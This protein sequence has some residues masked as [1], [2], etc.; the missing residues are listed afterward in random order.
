MKGRHRRG[1]RG[2]QRGRQ[3]RRGHSEK[4]KKK[5]RAQQNDGQGQEAGKNCRRVGKGAKERALEL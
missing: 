5:K 2:G 1:E 4:A 3:G